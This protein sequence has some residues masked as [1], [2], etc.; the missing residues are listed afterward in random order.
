MVNYPAGNPII[1]M[2]LNKKTAKANPSFGGFFHT[3]YFSPYKF[4]IRDFFYNFRPTPVTQLVRVLNYI[5]Y[6]S[7]CTQL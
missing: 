6:L 3:T 4:Y 5:Q 7:V 1:T 2:N